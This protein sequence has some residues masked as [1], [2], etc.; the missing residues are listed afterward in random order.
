MILGVELV[1]TEPAELVLAFGALHEL[2]ATLS[3]YTDF[4]TRANLSTKQLVNIAE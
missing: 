2:A 1:Q 4:A 3:H